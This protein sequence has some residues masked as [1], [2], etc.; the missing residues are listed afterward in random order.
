MCPSLVS[1]YVPVVSFILFLL[2][3][4]FFSSGPAVHNYILLFSCAP[5]LYCGV[6]LFWQTPQPLV[7]EPPFVDSCRPYQQ[8]PVSPSLFSVLPTWMFFRG[9]LAPSV[10]CS[11]LYMLHISAVLRVLRCDVIRRCAVE[12]RVLAGLDWCVKGLHCLV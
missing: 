11:E 12:R 6:V 7:M 2:L 4:C 9:K 5:R 3:L 1:V 10:F 8:R